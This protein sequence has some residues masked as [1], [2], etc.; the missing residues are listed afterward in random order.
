M[1][2]TTITILFTILRTVK[3]TKLAKLEYW[4]TWNISNTDLFMHLCPIDIFRTKKKLILSKVFLKPRG[5]FSFSFCSN[6]VNVFSDL[7]L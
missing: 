7:K 3:K 6:I 4:L 5:K 2:T 1:Y